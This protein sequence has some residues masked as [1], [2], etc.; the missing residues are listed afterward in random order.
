MLNALTDEFPYG[1]L[2]VELMHQFMMN[3]KKH[4]TVKNTNAKFG[5]GTDSGKEFE[6]LDE[7]LHLVSEHSFAKQLIRSTLISKIIGLASFKIN[8]RLAVFR[9]GRTI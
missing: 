1:Y 9:W 2:L 5:W 8:N 6:E 4:D 7:R 3:E